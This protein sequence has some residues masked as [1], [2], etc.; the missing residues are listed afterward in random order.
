MH[1]QL[2]VGTNLVQ[3]PAPEVQS[4]TPVQFE[5]GV[6]AVITIYGKNFGTNFS[7]VNAYLRLDG[8]GEATCDESQLVSDAQ[9]VCTLLPKKS[10]K[11]EGVFV[12]SVGTDWS[13]GHQNSS[14]GINSRVKEIDLPVEVTMTIAK[15]FS[16]IPPGSLALAQFVAEFKSDVARAIGVPEHRINVTSVSPGSVI[17]VFVILP[18][19]LSLVSLSPATAAAEIFRQASN[20]SVSAPSRTKRHSNH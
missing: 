3:Y 4:I 2:S 12:I 20:P 5:P 14:T 6:T 7:E 11:N 13:G 17:V 18:D 16:T 10:R 1:K 8:G 19:P 15:E 9:F